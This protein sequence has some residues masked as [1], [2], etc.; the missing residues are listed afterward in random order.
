MGFSGPGSSGKMDIN[1]GICFVKENKIPVG[2]FEYG[3]APGGLGEPKTDFFQFTFNYDNEFNGEAYNYYEPG[4]ENSGTLTIEGSNPYTVTLS[5]KMISY[6]E[7]S[8][9]KGTAKITYQGS[10]SGF[11]KLM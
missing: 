2:I 5:F 11:N 4:G 10:I 6:G 7:T 9:P 1:F 8:E 3:G